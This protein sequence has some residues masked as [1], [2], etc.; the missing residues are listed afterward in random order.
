MVSGGGKSLWHKPS[1]ESKTRIKSVQKYGK[2]KDLN[3]RWKQHM[4][5]MHKQGIIRKVDITKLSRSLN[6]VRMQICNLLPP[7]K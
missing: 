3:N 2:M 1:F 4:N 6:I 5:Y 7:I